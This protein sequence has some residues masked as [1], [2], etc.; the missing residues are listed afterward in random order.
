VHTIADNISA[1]LI[2][3][4]NM[5]TLEVEG[6]PAGIDPEEWEDATGEKFEWKYPEWENV[7]SFEPSDSSE[8]FRI[9]ENFAEQLYN[10][11][12]RNTLIDI[13]NR[14]K[15]FAHFNSY[16]HNSKYRDE[17]FNFKNANLENHV[18]QIIYAKLNETR[19]QPG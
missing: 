6:Y 14:P 4:L 12:V 17:W 5:D 16:I 1:G 3:H 18:R 19:D 15:P 10:N 11:K 8:S 2:C 7:L 9:M 13:L